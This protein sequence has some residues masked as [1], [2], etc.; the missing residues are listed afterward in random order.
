MDDTCCIPKTGDVDWLLSHLYSLR[1]TIKFTIELEE[2]GSLPFLDTRVT[3][4]TNRKLDITVYREKT[5]TDRY[6]HFKSHH[7]THIK[8]GTVRCLYDQA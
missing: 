5:H 3:R 1:P 7:P 6:L 2:E 8:I 4:L